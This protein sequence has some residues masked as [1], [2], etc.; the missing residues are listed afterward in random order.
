MFLRTLSIFLYNTFVTPLN[1]TP[2]PL[3]TPPTSSHFTST[4]LPL[5]HPNLPLPCSSSHPTLPLPCFSYLTSP[6]PHSSFPSIFLFLTLPLNLFLSSILSPYPTLPTLL[7]SPLL[8]S[9][10]LGVRSAMLNF[11]EIPNSLGN[12]SLLME[13]SG[14]KIPFIVENLQGKISLLFLYRFFP[15]YFLMLVTY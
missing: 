2:P 5:P 14:H 6:H 11:E 3:L 15:F 12:S 1:P 9:Y 13:S 7:P 10:S 8:P 4:H